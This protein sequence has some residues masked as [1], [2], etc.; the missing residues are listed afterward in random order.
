M[1]KWQRWAGIMKASPFEEKRLLKW[2]PPFIVQ[3]KYDGVRCRAVPLDNGEYMLLSSGENPIF[4]VPHINESLLTN[5]LSHHYELDGE[6]YCH[7]MSFEDIVSITSRTTNLHSNHK[8]IKF[9]IFDIV[10][11]DTQVKR[12]NSLYDI[13]DK[14]GYFELAPYWICYNLDCIMFTYDKII[15]L[16]YEGI[17]VRNAYAPY[18]RKRST[19]VMKF[20]PKKRDDYEIVG[21]QEEI[22]IDGLAKGRLGSFVCKSG[23]GNTFNVG[24]GLSAD[25]RQSYW[26]ERET[27]IGKIAK[28]KYQ[29]LTSGKNVPRFPVFVTLIE[30][31]KENE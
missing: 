18:E 1:N 23:D 2:E 16:G 7:G 30:E 22:S 27:L 20:K 5:N 28:V 6:L 19:W 13:A 15:S 3:P 31:E 9:H 4:S 24:T 17:V 14:P 12:L 25:Q 10:S 21:F 8:E 11:Q 29:H 26:N